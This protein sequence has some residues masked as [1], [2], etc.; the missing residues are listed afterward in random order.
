MN[1]AGTLERMKAKREKILEDPEAHKSEQVR[2][3]LPDDFDDLPEETQ[4]EI[5]AEL[6]DAV[7]SIDPQ[8][9]KEEIILECCLYNFI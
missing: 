6:E 7:V 5:I 4:E 2:K 8:D 3:K 9:L 1:S